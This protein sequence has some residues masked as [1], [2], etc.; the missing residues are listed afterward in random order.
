MFT[1]VCESEGVD[2]IGDGV[3]QEH[4]KNFFFVRNRKNGTG[5]QKKKESV[6]AGTPEA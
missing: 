1:P 6:V 3:G 5:T 4:E 2:D